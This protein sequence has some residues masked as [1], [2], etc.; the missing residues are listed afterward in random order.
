M[1]QEASSSSFGSSTSTSTSNPEAEGRSTP[2]DEAP[3]PEFIAEQNQS[4]ESGIG[5]D[6]SLSVAHSASDDH[7]G[8]MFHAFSVDNSYKALK[9]I[10]VEGANNGV[11]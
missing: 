2:P 9:P 5:D 3:K 6:A 10:N 11:L 1:D 7:N 4:T 8:S